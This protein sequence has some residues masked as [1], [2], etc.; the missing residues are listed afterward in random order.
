MNDMQFKAFLTVADTLSFTKAANQMFMTQ[1]AVSK[2]VDELEKALNLV[3]FERTKTTVK[4]TQ[5]GEALKRLLREFLDDY[6]KTRDRI[7][8]H[9][10]HMEFKFKVG[11]SETVDPFG[12]IWGGINDFIAQNPS[13]VLRGGQLVLCEIQEKLDTGEYDL[14]I[15]SRRNAPLGDGYCVESFAHERQCLYGPE[16]ICT[17]KLDEK[18]WGLPLILLASWEWGYFAWNRIGPNALAKLGLHPERSLGVPNV[19]SQLSEM[20]LHKFVTIADDRFGRVAHLPGLV[21]FPLKT[22]GTICCAWKKSNEN[23][24]IP[25]FVETL[26]AYTAESAGN[27]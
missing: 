27:S 10:R 8:D 22:S 25:R 1:Q 26:R 4:L 20:R 3:L 17:G 5:E 2:H 11:I 16:S 12:E 21:K 7:D 19:E 24:L 6:A 13:T 14:V 9:Y 18:C 23:P 15:V